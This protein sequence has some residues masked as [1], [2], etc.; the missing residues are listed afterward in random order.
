MLTTL[1]G[2]TSECSV[3]RNRWFGDVLDFSK[4]CRWLV[5]GFVVS[6]LIVLTSPL[7]EDIACHRNNMAEVGA[8]PLGQRSVYLE[9]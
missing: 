1:G 4:S 2:V 6:F 9:V 5:Y 3:H 8:N 7:E